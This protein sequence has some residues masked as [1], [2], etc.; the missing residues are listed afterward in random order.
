MKK[1]LI[2]LAVTAI[3][4]SCA[5]RVTTNLIS[6][7]S[8]LPKS[9]TITVFNVND[10]VPGEPQKLGSISIGDTGFTTNCNYD[11]VI[12]LA[13][14][15][16]R[17]AG[18]NAIKITEH[19][20]PNFW[21]SSCH[22]IKADILRLAASPNRD[23]V[24]E[25]SMNL[26]ESNENAVVNSYYTT[27]YIPEE[28][29]K[30]NI[31]LGIGGGYRI[32]KLSDALSSVERDHMKKMKWGMTLELNSE[33][34]VSKFIGIGISSSWFRSAAAITLLQQGYS[35]EVKDRINLFYVGPKVVFRGGKGKSGH[36]FAETSLGYLGYYQVLKSAD[37]G[38]KDKYTGNSLG[39]IL[40]LGYDINL[41]QVAGLVLKLSMTTGTMSKMTETL[42]N[43]Q[44]SV[45]EFPDG[46]K[47]GLSR[48]DLTVGIR[49]RSK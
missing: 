24:T 46:K 31:S 20:E 7:H 49:F 48:I 17:K 21:G 30:F 22:R 26:N 45:I 40:G 14:E 37:S 18:G 42:H 23:A 47:E 15:E 19:K 8:S 38:L 13:K 9:S 4:Y 2:L 32:N 28:Y 36:F 39:S 11:K 5:P 16:A 41:S 34:Y 27:T 10:K 1:T 12:S 44:K 29:S 25:R 33:V 3:F 35:Y 43:G 6:R